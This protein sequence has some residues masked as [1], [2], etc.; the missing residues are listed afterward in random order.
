MCNGLSKLT[1]LELGDRSPKSQ[2][3]IQENMLQYAL[4]SWIT[5]FFDICILFIQWYNNEIFFFYYRF[6]PSITNRL[7][8]NVFDKGSNSSTKHFALSIATRLK[9]LSSRKNII[10]QSLDSVHILQSGFEVNFYQNWKFR[11]HEYDR[12]F[13]LRL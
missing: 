8:V 7:S 1:F 6:S 4:P 3:L 11:N 12:L 2:P 5:I 9:A 10:Q 13:M